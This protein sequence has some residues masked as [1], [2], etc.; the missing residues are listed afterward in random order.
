ME[1]WHCLIWELNTN[2]MDLT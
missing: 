1:T 2:F